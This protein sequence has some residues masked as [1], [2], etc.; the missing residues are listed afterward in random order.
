MKTIYIC[1][2]SVTGIFS[3]VYEAWKERR[4][5]GASGIA[6]RGSVEPQLF[7]EYREIPENESRAEA[8]VRMILTNLGRDVYHHIYYAALSRDDE[9][10][11]A[12]LGTLLAARKLGQPRNIMEHLGNP[13]VEKV[14]ELSRSVGR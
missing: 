11:E 5:E 4:R 13:A 9:K 8:V 7:C 14:F 3:A 6:I 12:I 2:D 10:G 1:T